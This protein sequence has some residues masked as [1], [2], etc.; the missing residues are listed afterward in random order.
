MLSE[1][2]RQQLYRRSL[3]TIVLLALLIAA[4]VLIDVVSAK[5]A[6]DPFEL[7][8]D[9]PRG[10]L[11][12]AQFSDLPAML[13]SWEAS[14]LKRRYVAGTSFQQLQTR[15]LALKLV[16]R[17][18]E[19]NEATG[20]EI[21]PG[22]LG[23]LADN[24]AAIAVYDI[25][26]LDLVLI[27]PMSQ[28][29]YEACRF[30]QA[31]ESFAPV[32]LPDGTSYYLHDV[33]ADRG[34]QKQQ[35]GF[36]W[37]KGRFVLAT[38]EKLLLR[39]IANLNGQAKKDRLT[40][41]PSFQTLSRAVTPHFATVWVDQARLNDDWYFR[42]YWLM[43]R[44]ADLKQIRAGIFDVEMK[45]DRWIERRE[46][47]TTGDRP[48]ADARFE[49]L[50]PNAERQIA[51]IV[52]AEI[53]FVQVRALGRDPEAA[54]ALTQEV[55]FDAADEPAM[56]TAGWR[57]N[58]YDE[59][60]F[61]V[62]SEDEE[63]YGSSRYSYLSYRYNLFIDD[64]D[65][66][67]EQNPDES[68]AMRRATDQRARA[69]IR[70]SL[71]A[72]RPVSGAKLARPRAIDGPLF[73]EFGR[74]AVFALQQPAAL[75]RPALEAAIARIA[76]NR[77]MIAGA[78]AS[79]VWRDRNEN[80]VA[81]R[82]LVF[83][84]LGRS[85]GYGLRGPLLLLS[86]SPDLLATLMTRQAQHPETLPPAHER[87]LLRLDQRAEAFDRIF[88]KLDAPR[89][90]AYWKQRK[91]DQV[92]PDAPSQEFFSGNLASLLDAAAPVREIRIERSYAPGRLHEEV[93]MMMQKKNGT[94]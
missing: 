40:D 54:P 93:S 78:S 75:D 57:W 17:W 58:R 41:D 81:W 70:A 45:S 28:E 73:A 38:G 7:A 35:I 13:K 15:H 12:Y 77:T 9:A 20:F 74:A 61:E 29:R 3:L 6:A 1:I 59:S 2:D 26:K 50:A 30:F 85:V 5:R 89:I 60:D 22:V 55:L 8:A 63:Y 10:A 68:A 21:D 49:T 31:R 32:E 43:S 80:G 69:M 14:D 90:Q 87:T 76:A 94:N 48:V 4:G 88:A 64:P 51:A 37:V 62:A 66:A 33:E 56:K 46:F 34:R 36:A 19:F 79:F 27:A 84:A 23:G 47:L 24:R 86:N 25:G 39:T 67:G 16:S 71:Q 65:D 42:H 52:P 82:E 44:A 92:R 83:P 18:S 91:G 53:P 11:V 72:A